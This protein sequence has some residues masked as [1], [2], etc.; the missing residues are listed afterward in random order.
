MSALGVLS[1]AYLVTIY[2]MVAVFITYIIVQKFSYVS[3]FFRPLNR[4][5]HLFIKEGNAGRSLIE[6]FA[7]HNLLSYVKILNVTFNILTP[8]YFYNMNGTLGHPHVYND[9]HTEYLS[10]QHLTYFVLA[11]AMSFV[12]NFL[13]SCSFLCTLVLVSRSISTG[14][15]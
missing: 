9:P 7:T 11:I 15:Y 14:Q 3:C 5:L 6:A 13:P 4:C 8:I 12:F 10:K 1:L 2:P